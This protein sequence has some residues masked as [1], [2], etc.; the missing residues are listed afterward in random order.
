[1]L[2]RRTR[3]LAGTVIACALAL[4]PAAAQ[5]DMPGPGEG[6][7]GGDLLLFVPPP[8]WQPVDQEKGEGLY[9]IVY[10]PEGQT[11]ADWSELLEAKIF[12]NL[13]KRRPQLSPAD[14]TENLVAHY[15]RACEGSRA[16]PVAAFEE[17]G[18]QAAVRLVTCA[19]NRGESLGSVSMVKVVRG[20]ASLFMIERSWRGP[21][22]AREEM[23]VPQ[24]MLDRWTDFLARARLCNDDNPLSPC[25][26][27]MGR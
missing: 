12:F 21:A 17:R 26:E 15:A 5:D 16:S 13:T 24:E 3:R 7:P 4:A 11:M 1:M 14:F 20:K 2:C 10:V 23:P 19:R 25:P 18:Y 8:G 6:D 9:R 27:G 22:F